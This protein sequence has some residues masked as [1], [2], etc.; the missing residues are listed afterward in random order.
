MKESSDCPSLSV[1]LQQEDL[2][3]AQRED[4]DIGPVLHQITQGEGKPSPTDL[5]RS[6][7]MTR[8]IW[9]QF[10]LLHVVNDVLYINQVQSAKNRLVLLAVLVKPALEILLDGPGGNYMVAEKTLKSL[11]LET[12]NVYCCP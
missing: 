6:S 1:G 3:R 12:W 2:A 11:F 9:A 4:P 7:T 10:E 8:A 5:Q